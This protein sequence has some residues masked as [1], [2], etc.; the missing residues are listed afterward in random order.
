MPETGACWDAEERVVMWRLE[1]IS[2]TSAQ[3]LRGT[4]ER[5]VNQNPMSFC[6]RC[7]I[8]NFDTNEVPTTQGLRGPRRSPA[9]RSSGR[10]GP[11]D[12]LGAPSAKGRAR[13]GLDS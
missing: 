6:L 5:T 8:S 11:L 1:L 7:S 2:F 3:I 10:P 13:A 9:A 12:A 4:W